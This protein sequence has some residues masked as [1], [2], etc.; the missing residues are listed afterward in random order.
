MNDDADEWMKERDEQ[1]GDVARVV[2]GHS[3]HHQVPQ[4]M[5][6]ICNLVADPWLLCFDL[7]LSLIHLLVVFPAL[8]STAWGRNGGSCRTGTSLSMLALIRLMRWWRMPRS[9]S[10]QLTTPCSP[11]QEFFFL[12]FFIILCWRGL[13]SAVYIPLSPSRFFLAQNVWMHGS[14]TFI[15]A[16]LLCKY[17]HLEYNETTDSAA[18]G[19]ITR[20]D[21]FR[22]RCQ[23]V[24]FYWLTPQRHV[25][26]LSWD[27]RMRTR[28]SPNF[29]EGQVPLENPQYRGVIRKNN[30]NSIAVHGFV[31]PLIP[32][33]EAEGNVSV[34]RSLNLQ[35]WSVCQLPGWGWTPVLYSDNLIQ[36]VIVDV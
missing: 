1:R 8:C 17:V 21:R 23:G 26:P 35:I 12:L 6:K 4:I 28:R 7:A 19:C 14:S 2:K 36:G 10:T 27:K 33:W 31:G 9:R 34:L 5:L 15:P 25:I 20:L 30:A 18:V 32:D 16:C 11:H 13:G 3:A 29:Q 22:W 24:E